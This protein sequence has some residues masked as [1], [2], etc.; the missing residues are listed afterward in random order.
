M[1]AHNA[2]ETQTYTMA[3][4]QFSDW[5]QE[6]FESIMLT[7]KAVDV[8]FSEDDEDLAVEVGDVDWVSQG[9]VTAV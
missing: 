6:E 5:T 4:N 7:L 3:I 1:I 2:D 9:A 8:E